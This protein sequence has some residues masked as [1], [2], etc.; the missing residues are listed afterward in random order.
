MR[1]ICLD[2]LA[3]GRCLRASAGTQ[4]G[5]PWAA[6]MG[7]GACGTLGSKNTTAKWR[8]AIGMTLMQHLAQ[9]IWRYAIIDM[10][11]IYVLYCFNKVYCLSEA[12]EALSRWKSISGSA[13][14]PGVQT[15]SAQDL[16]HYGFASRSLVNFLTGLLNH[17]THTKLWSCTCSAA[18]AL[19]QIIWK[20]FA[21]W[22]LSGLHKA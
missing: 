1:N 17:S 18:S 6:K 4:Y 5:V 2:Y 9:K 8:K 21:Q 13:R 3:W 11:N 14:F 15:L 12:V 20:G 7:G 22:H 16:E 10:T 19:C